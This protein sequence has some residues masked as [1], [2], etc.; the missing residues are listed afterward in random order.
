MNPIIAICDFTAYP[1]LKG[2]KLFLEQKLESIQQ[3]KRDLYHPSAIQY[4]SESG[5]S[6]NPKGTDKILISLITEEQKAVERL[7]VVNARLEDTEKL[8]FSLA[9]PERDYVR[10]KY[11]NRSTWEEMEKKFLD[12][13]PSS[14]NGL[15]RINSASNNAIL[16]SG[17]EAPYV[18]EIAVQRPDFC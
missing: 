8:V 14:V 9:Y 15:S 18:Q 6:Q 4:D 7:S 10:E 17:R 2:E 11:F 5:H 12:R 3:E 1:A 16:E 13:L